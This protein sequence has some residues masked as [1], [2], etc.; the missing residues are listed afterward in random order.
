ML[1]RSEA[2]GTYDAATSVTPN[3]PASVPSAIGVGGSSATAPA[4]MPNLNQLAEQVTRM[5]VR[6]LEVERD[7]RGGKTWL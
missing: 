5:I 4:P 7:R 3:T 1:L 2:E 6:R